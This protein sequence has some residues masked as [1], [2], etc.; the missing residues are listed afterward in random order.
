M[1]N[2]L[3]DHAYDSRKRRKALALR[4]IR[5]GIMRRTCRGHPLSNGSSAATPCCA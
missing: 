5:N 1:S 4:D 2:G 3:G